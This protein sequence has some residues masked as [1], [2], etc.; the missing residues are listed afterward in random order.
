[1][2]AHGKSLDISTEPRH[3]E[4][5]AGRV[6]VV[7]V[8]VAVVGLGG[9]VALSRGAE[10]GMDRLLETYLVSFAFWLSV[11]LGGLF[12]VLLQ[13]LT[14]AGWSVVVRRVAEA[15]AA[16]VHLM[17]LLVVPVLLGMHH[18]YHWSHA[19]AVAHD[20]ILAGKAGFLNPTFF[21]V[22]VVIYFLIWS[23][24]AWFFFRTSVKQDASGDPALTLRM[25]RVSAPGMILFALSLNF[26]AFDLLMSLDPH[27]FSTIFG[28]YYFAGSVVVFC[29]LMP[30][31][32]VW[33]QSTGRLRHA[34]TREHYHDFGKLLF[35]FTVFWA[36]IAFSQYMLI[37]Y[38]HLPEETGWF[39]KR[40]TGSWVWVS[41]GLLFGHFVVPFLILISRLFKRRPGLLALAGAWMIVMH[42]IDMYW[43][44][45][46]EFSPTGPHV[47]VV[48]VLVFFGMGGLFFLVWALRL[49]R[50]PL[51]PE[52]DP[53]LAESLAFE[54]A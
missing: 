24:L 11:A 26:A 33:L 50:H 45:G 36:Y 30:I 17:F 20:P 27:W 23:V 6:A 7:A 54:N 51:V 43:L 32:M 38:A 49:R 5:L 21:T 15:I 4:G 47:G 28:V 19:D 2:H 16:N 29:A 44:A 46:P 52:R 22:R 40:Q 1:M 14:R 10:H 39:L 34:L 48:D 41:L 35:A 18:L 13:H 3:L 8:I 12:F 53:R 25:E 37:W 9:A 42:W 31:L